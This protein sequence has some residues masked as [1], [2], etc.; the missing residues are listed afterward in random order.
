MAKKAVPCK[1]EI[2]SKEELIKDPM[3]YINDS[4]QLNIEIP[5]FKNLDALNKYLRK[6]YNFDIGGSLRE[7]CDEDESEEECDENP[8]DTDDDEYEKLFYG[9]DL[10][11]FCGFLWG[12]SDLPGVVD[13]EF[14]EFRFLPRFFV[15]SGGQKDYKY[16]TGDGNWKDTYWKKMIEDAEII[17]ID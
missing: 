6:N 17:E 16:D 5:S 14:I 2:P 13:D 9:A 12:D 4:I 8:Y 10:R 3:K 7:E 15:G 11:S 1:K